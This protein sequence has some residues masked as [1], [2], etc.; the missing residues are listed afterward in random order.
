MKIITRFPPSP[1]G[2][3]HIGSAR[4]AL[5]NYLFAAHEGGEMKL[6]FE[7]TDT[8]RNK[9]EFEE[10]ILAGLAWLGIPYTQASPL[11]QSERTDTYRAHLKALIESGAAF[12]AEPSAADPDTPIIRFKNPKKSVSFTDLV[13]GEVTFETAD[14]GDF[15]IAKNLDEPLYNLAV[16]IDDHHEEVTHVLRGE[17]HIS[18]T[19][20]Q[21][22]LLEALGFSRPQY[23]HIPLILAPD[24]SKLS[25]RHGAVSVN[26]Y[27]NEGFMPEALVNY[28]ALLGWNPGTE[29]E[30]FSIE[31]LVRAFRME[32]V[33]KGGAI[34][35]A[36]KLRWFNHKHIMLLSDD[37]YARRLLH[38]AGSPPPDKAIPL[39]KERAHTLR[40]AATLL[41]SGEFYFLDN[42][43]SYE[44]SLLISGAKIDA[45]TARRHLTRVG[46]MLD[47][48]PED[49]FDAERVKDAVFTYATEEGRGAVLWPLRV[50]LSGKERSPDPF[51]IAGMIGKK[52]TLERVRN[53]GALLASDL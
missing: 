19:P 2:Y 49:S 1:T 4:T 16:V 35:D 20:R 37:E 24:R 14:L 30:I 50:A 3:F 39:L 12:E 9:K 32:Q 6:R 31:E 46:E 17:D 11:R 18:N 51:T 36:D 10:D 45:E 28:L 22:L 43:I 48:I 42:E 47:D 41:E 53:A 34:F 33:Q 40:E 5:F 13:R 25:K 29:Q 26:E 52:R 15:V 44:P 23:A 38:F 21:I 7:D 8:T 27:R